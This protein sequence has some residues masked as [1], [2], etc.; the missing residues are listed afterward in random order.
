MESTRFTDNGDGT[1]SDGKTGLTWAKEDSWQYEKRW[2]SWDEAEKYVDKLRYIRLADTQDWR[3]PTKSELSSLY[4]PDKINKDKYGKEIHLDPIFPEGS[5]A[6]NWTCEYTGNDAYIVDFSS[7]EVNQ[8]YK[9]KA[10][11][12]AARAVRNSGPKTSEKEGGDPI[13]ED[14]F[15]TAR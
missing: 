5:Q 6:K 8:L 12:M 10:G 4:E 14:K 3:L 11:R 15:L 13:D 2:V 9:S 1:I 7:G